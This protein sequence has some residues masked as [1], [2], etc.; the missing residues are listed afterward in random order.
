MIM[1]DWRLRLRA[2]AARRRVERELDEEL[3]FHIECETRKLIAEGVDAADARRLALA[4]FGPVALAA[5]QCRDERGLSF[6]DTL[7]GDFLFALRT[8]RRAPLPALTVVATIALGL[9]V[10]AVA[11]TFFNGLFL[12]MDAVRDPEELYAVERPLR[13]ASRG[14]IP[15]T[16]PEYEA[17]RREAGVF[18]DVAALRGSIGTRIDGRAVRGVFVSGNFFEMLGVSAALGRTLVSADNEGGGRAVVVLSHL[19]WKKLFDADR[20]AVG[21]RILVNGRPYEVAGVM[22]EDFRGLRQEPQDYWAPLALLG[23]FLPAPTQP[24]KRV[25]LIARLPKGASP[26]A[27]AAALSAWATNRADAPRPGNGA[28]VPVI[29]RENRGVLSKDRY[30]AMALF[31]PVFIA[32]GLILMIGC[33]NVANLLLARGVSRQREIGI[34]LSLGATRGRILRQLLTENAILAVAAAALAFLISRAMLAGSIYMMLSVLPAEFSESLDVVVP[35]GDWRVWVFL[36]G[37][38]L[39][40]TVAFGLVPALQVTRLDPVRA[41]RGHADSGGRPGRIRQ[42]LIA[43]Q[44]T[45]SAFLLICAAVFLRSTLASATQD[46]GVR[47][48]DTV[49]VTGITE[50][51]RPALLRALRQQPSVASIAASWP[52]PMDP[53]VALEA[54]AGG[55]KQLVNCKLV[56]PEYFHL[57]GIPTVRGRLFAPEEGSTATGVVVLSE[58]AARRFWPHGDA[59]GQAIRLDNTA[60]GEA[61]AAAVPAR[62][63]TV[64]GVVR[65]VRNALPGFDF[66]YSGV[67]LPATALRENA[68]LIVRVHGDPERVRRTLLD[69]LTLV[70]PALGGITTMKMM[71]RLSAAVLEVAFWMAVMLGSLALALTVSGL[72]SVLS[73]LVEQRR[74]EIG[75]RL[76][77]GA[78]PHDVLKLVAAQAMRPVAGGVLAGGGIALALA[79]V[80]LSTPLAGPIGTMVRAF[81]PLAYAG[82]AAV[83]TG[84]CL[85][86]AMLPA[87][88]AARIE[89]MATL[90]AD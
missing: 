82:G 29:L 52:E 47:T 72:F 60:S 12:R 23:E 86:A 5:D 80:L 3:A 28:A 90:R 50:A 32:F 67:Y 4:R 39:G 63:Y 49:V 48:G 21:R 15:F 76:A 7:A 74:R 14:E 30:Q 58:S 61:G 79:V 88:R 44:V 22:P 13:G 59:L 18:T 78:E 75:V 34:R 38:A 2:L 31:V 64:V 42:M 37:S 54:A 68:S 33:A 1:R 25:E 55:A 70:D 89:P 17:L 81:D 46:A 87:K 36:F 26:A 83:I 45:A 73:Y 27:A 35:P 57:L 51:S 69:A 19:G 71:S 85:A 56:S 16:E 8:F 43:S 65:D 77:L 62:S 20:G 24:P 41:M 6:F 66:S 9:G 11:F 84:T 53:G 10:L 40:A